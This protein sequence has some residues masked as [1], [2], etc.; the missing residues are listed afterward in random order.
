MP[1]M[2]IKEIIKKVRYD[3]RLTQQ[4]LADKVGKKQ[5]DIAKYESG[6][7]IPPG[8]VLLKIMEIGQNC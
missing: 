4:E 8:D 7:T 1:N 2:D 6:Q 5:P 3:A